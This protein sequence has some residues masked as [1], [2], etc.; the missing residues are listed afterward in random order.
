MRIC[1]WC[2]GELVWQTGEER[3]AREQAGNATEKDTFNCRGCRRQYRH[4]VHE[5]FSGDSEWWGVRD[6]GQNDWRDL[7]EKMWPR[8]K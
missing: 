2:N 3:S 6:R 1:A 5:R 7:D 8:F 4:V